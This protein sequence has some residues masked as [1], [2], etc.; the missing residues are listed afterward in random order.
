MVLRSGTAAARQR[1]DGSAD[2]LSILDGDPNTYVEFA[3]EYFERTLAPADVA[4]VYAHQ[5]LTPALV[6]RI[7]PEIALGS[8]AGDIAEIGYP[9]MR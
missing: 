6:Q 4:A 8:L 7:N 9:E 3:A 2:L 1:P 5:P